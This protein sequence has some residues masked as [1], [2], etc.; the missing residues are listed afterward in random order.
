M[1]KLLEDRYGRRHDYLRISVT[2]RCNLRCVYCMGPEGV[3]LLEHRQILSY[4]EILKIVRA[5]AEVGV[6]KIR[7]TGGEP[8]VRK[9][10][11]YLIKKIAETPGIEDIAMTTNGL[12]LEEKALAL[13][14]AGLKRVNVS[15]DSLKPETY[16][17]VTRGGDLNKA[18]AGIKAAL[19]Y[20]LTPVKI[21][22]VLMKGINDEEIDDFLRLTLEYPLH[23]RF[24]EYMPIDAHDIAWEGKYLSLQAVKE[25]ASTLGLPLE[26]IEVRGCGPA[27]MFKLPGALGSVGLIHPVS[28]HFC[29]SCNRLR[30][31]ADGYLKPCLYWQ[32]EL[33]V[34]PVLNDKEALQE[35]FR[36][37]LDVK[38]QQHTMSPQ[39][40]RDL[41]EDRR[42]MSKVGG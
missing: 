23:V 28:K 1:M 38:R 8:L 26:S 15:L 30:L 7:I 10:I 34:R 31:T 22:V 25:R 41:E 4:E 17:Q 9:G 14:E 6:K 40:N 37:A 33:P 42:G 13:K 11:E 27:E 12:L 18:L 32:E 29:F 2:D 5:A 16:S 21:N 20:R 19:H 39:R 3:K 35:L 24:I 36:K